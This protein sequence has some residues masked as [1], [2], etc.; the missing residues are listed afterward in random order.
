MSKAAAIENPTT[1]PARR[2]S[3][4]VRGALS[5]VLLASLPACDSLFSPPVSAEVRADAPAGAVG[6]RVRLISATDFQSTGESPPN[7]VFTHADTVELT[8]P[9]T[10]DVEIRSHNGQRKLYL[11]V[12]SLEAGSLPVRLRVDIQ[13]LSW[14]DLT[15]DL[16]DLRHRFVFVRG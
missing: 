4:L 11:E 13:D 6:K 3:L 10:R 12:S 15:L 7:V 5:S 16:L 9:F 14:Y 8:L 2:R 1:R